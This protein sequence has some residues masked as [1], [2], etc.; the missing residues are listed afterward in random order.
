MPLRPLVRSVAVAGLLLVASATAAA[1]LAAQG[2]VSRLTRDQLADYVKGEGFG[3]IEVQDSVTLTTRMEGWKVALTITSGGESVYA[4]FGRT[5]TRATLRAVND[6]NR[7]IRYSRAY[8]DEDGDPVLELDL[9]LAG[10][11]MPERIRD[12]LRTVRQSVSRF[13]AEVK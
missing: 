10:G 6:W 7:D 8:I 1:S 4:Y 11:V 13:A 5:G 2:V 9:D 3:T 12:F